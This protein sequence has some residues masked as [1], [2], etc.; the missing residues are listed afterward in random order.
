METRQILKELTF[1]LHQ[2]TFQLG[3]FITASFMILVTS[4][5]NSCSEKNYRISNIA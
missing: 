4:V 2:D 5:A 3:S 1:A